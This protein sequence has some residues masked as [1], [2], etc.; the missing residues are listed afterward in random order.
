MNIFGGTSAG[1]EHSQFQSRNGMPW[2]FFNTLPTPI[3]NPVNINNGLRSTVYNSETVL[4]EY[5]PQKPCSNSKS[6]HRRSDDYVKLEKRVDSDSEEIKVEPKTQDVESAQKLNLKNEEKEDNILVEVTMNSDVYNIN[7]SG[8]PIN[9]ESII[10]S[11]RATSAN[12]EKKE[13]RNGFQN[14]TS[15]LIMTKEGDRVNLTV[16]APLTTK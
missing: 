10:R 9:F 1:Q 16:E 12:D 2:P 15:V 14:P 3:N 6:T 13:E 5:E 4:I 7:K 11:K 8:A